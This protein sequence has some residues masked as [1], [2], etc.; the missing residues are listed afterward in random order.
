MSEDIHLLFAEDDNEDWM[1]IEE[2][3][4]K[5]TGV[6]WHR[7]VDGE[8]L[9]HYLQNTGPL[10][11]MI[12]LDLRMPRRDG[13]WVLEEIRK[14]PVLKHV[15]VTIMTTSKTEAD[16]IKSY[17]IGANAYLIKPPSF[18]DMAALLGKAYEFWTQVAR[19]PGV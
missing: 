1:L 8:S 4:E 18:E 12:M 2:A 9:V 16:I 15:P 7:C 11:H 5:C 14:D 6:K 13:F 10:P 17:A 3:L 19:I